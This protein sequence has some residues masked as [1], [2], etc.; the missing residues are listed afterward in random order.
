MFSNDNSFL[1]QFQQILSIL[2]TGTTMAVPGITSA[3]RER[4][5]AAGAGVSPRVFP[6]LPLP[7][8]DW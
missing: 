6:R 5:P 2:A 3:W 7:A 1:C 8:G 4:T